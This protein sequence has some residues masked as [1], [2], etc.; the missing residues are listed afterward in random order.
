[1]LTWRFTHKAP[2]RRTVAE[3]R[4]NIIKQG[5]RN[6]ISQR[7]HKKSNNEAIA[8]WKLDLDRVLH[9][10]N[11]RS[12]TSVWSPL[13]LLFQ[14]E[15]ETHVIESEI[16]HAVANTHT[17]V[18]HVHHDNSDASDVVPDPDDGVSN[19]HVASDIH[20]DT[21][22]IR[23]NVDDQNPGVSAPCALAVAEQPLTAA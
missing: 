2:N 16:H 1:M 23:G 22:K 18:S 15:F 20:L 4:R 13:T 5:K 14:T 7:F 19:T 21:S 12:I 3:I 17:I 11:V 6:A 10:F 8:S 9:D